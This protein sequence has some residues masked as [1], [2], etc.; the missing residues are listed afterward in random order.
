M[1]AQIDA[2]ERGLTAQGPTWMGF[3][4]NDT[5]YG[6]MLLHTASPQTLEAQAD[7]EDLLDAQ[8]SLSEQPAGSVEASGAGL[9]VQLGSSPPSFTS[10][11]KISNVRPLRPTYHP[12][13]HYFGRLA[14]SG[15]CWSQAPSLSMRTSINCMHTPADA[16]FSLKK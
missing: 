13:C 3:C 2:L 10:L 11:L 8:A 6:N 1:A 7:A 14:L 4:H 9:N 16:L 15:S 5:Q 12:V